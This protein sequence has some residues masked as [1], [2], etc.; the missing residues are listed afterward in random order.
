MQTYNIFFL[1]MC[2]FVLLLLSIKYIL[3]E[4]KY[5][6]VFVCVFAWCVWMCVCVCVCVCV[7]V[8]VCVCVCMCVCM[9]VCVCVCVLPSAPNYPHPF[10][11]P[12]IQQLLLMTKTKGTKLLQCLWKFT[13]NR[14]Y[15]PS[16]ESKEISSLFTNRMN[17]L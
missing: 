1:I 6:C 12:H 5:L 10:Q 9:C 17:G 16:A 3:Y 7:Y 4:E 8:C 14:S 13:I 2:H 11:P 15:F